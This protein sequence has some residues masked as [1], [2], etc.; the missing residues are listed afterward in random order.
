MPS[1]RGDGPRGRA[2]S[3][4]ALALLAACTASQAGRG[5]LG[6]DAAAEVG[7]EDA[8][9]GA[10]EARDATRPS[11]AA[12]PSGGDAA[13][14]PGDG[15]REA[16]FFDAC[17]PLELPG[18]RRRGARGELRPVDLGCGVARSCAPARRA[19][20]ASRASASCARSRR[21]SPRRALRPARIPWPP[22]RRT[23]TGMGRSTWPSRATRRRRGRDHPPRQWRRDLWASRRGLHA[24]GLRSRR[25]GPERG[26][27]PRPR[28]RRAFRCR[29]LARQGRRELRSHPRPDGP[30]HG[31]RRPGRP[32]RRRPPRCRGGRRLLRRPLRRTGRDLPR[33]RRWNVSVGRWPTC[34]PATRAAS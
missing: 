7:G 13:D 29:P 20:R 30:P 28:G 34:K 18:R 3:G 21:S 16:G 19:W 24:D 26:R 32:R 17:I 31:V 9:D 15:D 5:K 10:A 12:P 23:S 4:V 22:A 11:E 2:L 25:R 6:E 1:G 8:G 33:R 27:L 14:A